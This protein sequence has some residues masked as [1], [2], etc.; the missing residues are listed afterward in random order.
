[1]ERERPTRIIYLRPYWN[2]NGTR[3]DGFVYNIRTIWF[4]FTLDFFVIHLPLSFSLYVAL[5]ALPFTTSHLISHYD[6]IGIVKPN[7]FIE[8]C[9]L[10]K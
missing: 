3:T 6:R 10:P 5:Y 1:M 4:S 9:G 7:I 2:L 8:S